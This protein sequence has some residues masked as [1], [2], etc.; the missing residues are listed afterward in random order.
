MGPVQVVVRKHRPP[1]VELWVREQRGDVGEEAR[2]LLEA[3]IGPLAL[4]DRTP[5][6]SQSFKIPEC[7]Q[8]PDRCRR[9]AVAPPPSPR[10]TPGTPSSP[11]PPRTSWPLP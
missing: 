8:Q 7:L 3:D 1:L 5:P 6:K 4:V 2:G 11:P 10:G 9:A